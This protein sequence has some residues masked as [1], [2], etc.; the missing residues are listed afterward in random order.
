MT[1]VIDVML[2]KKG[3]SNTWEWEVCY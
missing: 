3:L 2:R 1:P